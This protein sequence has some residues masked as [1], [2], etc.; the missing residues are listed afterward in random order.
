MLR[1]HRLFHA[2]DVHHQFKADQLCFSSLSVTAKQ[3]TGVNLVVHR[4]QVSRFAVG[5]DYIRLLQEYR[6]VILHAGVVKS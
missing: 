5:N 6:Q 1:P 4:G 2:D 3:V